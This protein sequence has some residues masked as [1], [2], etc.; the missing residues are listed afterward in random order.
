LNCEGGKRKE[1]FTASVEGDVSLL[2]F[3]GETDDRTTEVRFWQREG[4]RG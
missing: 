3:R 1:F 4:E 2:L